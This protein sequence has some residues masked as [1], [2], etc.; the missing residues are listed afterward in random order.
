ML[1]ELSVAYVILLD[2]TD[3]LF[4]DEVKAL[5]IS[6]SMSQKAFAEALGVSYATVNR[7]ENGHSEPHKVVREHFKAYKAKV[8]VIPSKTAH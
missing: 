6:L 7:W 2:V 3:P 4:S 5:R 1:L 8:A